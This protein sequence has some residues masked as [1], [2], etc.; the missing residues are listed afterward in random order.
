MALVAAGDSAPTG[1]LQYKF[2]KSDMGNEPYSKETCRD[3][4]AEKCVGQTW[5]GRAEAQYRF[6]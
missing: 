2:L 4:L 1:G 3:S 5:D 6:A